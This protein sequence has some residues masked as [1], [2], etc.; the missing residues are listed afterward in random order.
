VGI[1]DAAGHLVTAGPGATLPVTL[2]VATNPG[3]GTLA[4]TRGPTVVAVGGVARFSGCALDQPGSGY[5][6]RADAPTVTGAGGAPFAVAPAGSPPGLTV[7]ASPAVITYGVAVHLTAHAALPAGANVAAEFDAG[8]S[9]VY[10]PAGETMTDATGLASLTVTPVITSSYRVRTT[11]PGT[12]LVEVS[13]PVRVT[14]IAKATLASSLA[15]G[16]TVARTTKITLT[17]TIR[18]SGTP[19]ARG[20]ARFDVYQRTSSGWV[21]RRT[22]YANASST[23]VARLTLSLTSIGSWWI[24]SR[25]EPTTTNGASAWTT[26]VRYLVDR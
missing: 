16:R 14:V 7:S 20:R 19:V 24:R 8:G 2:S 25:A 15:S 4:C 1:L 26:G 18:P 5:T 10:G 21:R 22:L 3:S 17:E 11:A 23:G 13:A 9:G 6:L 12:G